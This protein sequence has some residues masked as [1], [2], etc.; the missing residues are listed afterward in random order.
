MYHPF[1]TSLL[2]ITAAAIVLLYPLPS[3]ACGSY[4]PNNFLYDS[5]DRV[6]TAP[7]TAFRVGFAGLYPLP[8]PRPEFS[9]IP[10]PGGKS[11]TQTAQ[12]DEDELA[13]AL[14]TLNLTDEIREDILE[15]YTEVRDVLTVLAEVMSIRYYYMA[16]SEDPLANWREWLQRMR[17]SGWQYYPR[18]DDLEIPEAVPPQ[19]SLYLRGAISYYQ[20]DWSRAREYW[21]QVLNLPDQHRQY[22]ST[23]AAFMIGKILVHEDPDQAVEWF[24]RVRSMTRE[25]YADNLGLA[26]NSFKWEAKAELNRGNYTRAIERF[27]DFRATGDRSA[28]NPL[29]GAI[30]RTFEAGPEALAEAAANPAV[31]RAIT[32]YITSNRSSGSYY[33]RSS[34]ALES[35]SAWLDAIEATDVTYIENTDFLAWAAYQNG[36]FE[37]A[38]RWL[39]KAPDTSLAMWLQ[40]K[41]AMRDG[42][43]Q[44]AAVLLEQATLGFSPNERWSGYTVPSRRVLGELGTLQLTLE[45]YPQALHSLLRA[46]YWID[47]AYVAERVLTPDELKAYVDE[48]W[49]DP[50][51]PSSHTSWDPYALR[52][53]GDE[54]IARKIRYLLARRLARLGRYVD[55]W[56]YYPDPL[57]PRIDALVQYLRDAEDMSLSDEDRADLLW[58]AALITRHEGIDLLGTEYE[59]DWRVSRGN[60][61]GG[62]ISSVRSDPG[63]ALILSSSDSE[64]E[65]IERHALEVQPQKRWHYRYV[66]LDLAWAAIELMPDE[67]YETAHRLCV[68]GGW[69]KARDPETADRFYKAMVNR[70]RSTW[71]GQEADRIRWFPDCG[72]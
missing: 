13:E 47:A 32:V 23:W 10:P 11:W 37:M 61:W 14:Q 54:G 51:L 53:S 64:R 55:A 34:T 20:G 65:R 43:L 52:A 5:D 9:Y 27:M 46:N 4:F 50:G 25:G 24:Q 56:N 67:T 63:H 18:L 57:R 3:R 33:Y 30:G 35:G 69:V 49:P 71:L 38:R 31:S 40:S 60:G 7:Q 45:Q 48:N 29:L 26:A 17:A 16:S 70:C 72:H 1:K 59:P 15:D 8:Q 36:R 39:D 62:G 21:E 19:F 58:E 42:Q 66:A 12:S 41:L 22:R 2:L 44:E 28:L 6:L 68:A